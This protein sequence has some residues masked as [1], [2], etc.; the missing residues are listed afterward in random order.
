MIRR[1]GPYGAAFA[2][3]VS[4]PV[5]NVT[6]TFAQPTVQAPAPAPAPT[7]GTPAP[8]T[9]TTTTVSPYIPPGQQGNGP[10]GGGN[11]TGSSS[12]PRTG[13]E[14]DS[15]DIK[16]GGGGQTA[17]GGDH[18]PIFGDNTM[19]GEVPWLHVVKKGDTLWGICD[20]YFQNP[21]QWPR[22]WSYNPQIQ[23]PHWIYPGDQ[24]RLKNAGAVPGGAGASAPAP[25]G[26][27]IV[28]RRRQVPNDT[29]FLRDQ[30]F[31]D[32]TSDENWGE[33]TGA[34]VDK[35]F[36]T[37]S[38]EAY[39]HL[40]DKND[41][42][43]GTEL[44]IFRPVRSVG[45]GHVIQIL[46][47]IRINQYNPQTHIGRGTITESLDVIE[48]GAR[49]GPV[50]R[51][52]QVVPPVRNEK[53]IKA[54]IVASVHPHNFYGQNQVVFVDQGGEE[55]LKLG[56]RLFIIRRGDAWRRS[57]AT[58]GA[59]NRIS[60]ES[61]KLPDL[62]RT[63][64]TRDEKQYPD[65]IIGELRVVAVR[66]HSATCVVTQSKAELEKD[67]MAVARKGY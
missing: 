56:N 10:V 39:V 18:G 49:I 50:G 23:N 4:I 52:Y 66:P 12:R 29:V 59:A 33:L 35:M 38:D 17:Y 21:Y 54:H 7:G 36:L 47:T 28:D 64:G 22:I 24:V 11:A 8:T 31:I 37:S 63:P 41:V 14:T 27:S 62:E 57:L 16:Y 43:L 42:K 15:F 2:A 60:P 40:G 67:D 53:D 9:T 1:Y 20:S 26:S 61:E 48:R 58:P 3:L 5:S 55:G 25:S 19:R 32:D 6:V 34:P 51:R 45:N 44:T 46:G 30:G 13:N 65:E